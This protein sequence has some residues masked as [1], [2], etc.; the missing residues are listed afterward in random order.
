[1]ARD[2][3]FSSSLIF[4]LPLCKLEK[5]AAKLVGL[6][7]LPSTGPGTWR[8]EQVWISVL[9]ISVWLGCVSPGPYS[10]DSLP[11]GAVAVGREGLSC[12]CL[13]EL[14]GTFVLCCFEEK[15]GGAMGSVFFASDSPI[16]HLFLSGKHLHK[17]SFLLSLS[18]WPKWLFA[19][20]SS[21]FYSVL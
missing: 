6:G 7:Q 17:E 5:P 9:S 21:P 14:G 10:L 16:A 2:G 12:H 1:M 3:F 13:L 19:I 15:R 4:Y 20:V 8:T 18:R 11:F